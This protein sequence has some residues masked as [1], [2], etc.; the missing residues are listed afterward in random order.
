ME[1]LV[2][3]RLGQADTAMVWEGNKVDL[4]VSCTVSKSHSPRVLGLRYKVLL[5]MTRAAEQSSYPCL[6]FSI[7]T[8]SI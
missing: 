1:A 3:A 8:A 7:T 5:G 6:T 2:W 4:Q